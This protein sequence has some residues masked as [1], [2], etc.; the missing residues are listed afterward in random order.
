[1]SKM[2]LPIFNFN[3]AKVFL[4]ILQ[5]SLNDLSIEGNIFAHSGNPLLVMCLLYE[6]LLN[7]I[8]KFYSLKNACSTMMGQ[9]MKMSL[10]YIESV[11]DE[12]F[13]TSVMIEKDYSGRDSLRIAVE[14]EL[15]DL[16]QAPKVEAI[17]KRIYNSDFDQAG[18]LFE[19]STS[20]QIVFG[21][22]NV[23]LDPEEDMR[24][25]KKRDIER[26]P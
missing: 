18:N 16:I 15:L 25:Y 24:F 8:K 11:D 6:L 9:I 2:L 1:M 13:L 21:N 3:S 10:D 5:F 14:L 26:V 22:K 12:N 23:N 4:E 20:Y 19:M 7:M 17:I